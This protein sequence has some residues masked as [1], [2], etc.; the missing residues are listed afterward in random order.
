[1][2]LHGTEQRNS[3]HISAKIMTLDF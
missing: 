1:M 3:K 2:Q